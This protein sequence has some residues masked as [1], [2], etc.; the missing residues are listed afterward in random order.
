MC[1]SV[2]HVC[3]Y[4]YTHCMH[5]WYPEVPIGSP[6]T[7]VTFGCE[8]PYGCWKS[9]TGLLQEQ[10]LLIDKPLLQPHVGVFLTYMSVDHMC[11]QCQ[12]RIKEGI[13]YSRTRVTDNSGLPYGCQESNLGLLEVQSM[14]WI[15]DH[16]S[17]LPVC[18]LLL[19]FCGGGVVVGL[20]LFCFPSRQDPILQHRLVLLSGHIQNKL[21]QNPQA[22][23]CLFP[24]C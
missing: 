24:K 9:N 16:L 3:I 21:S 14:L 20:F 5:S 15:A 8:L 12:Q 19:L 17:A 10:V 4:T 7:G 11:V 23:F 22:S 18:C 6:E 1:M 13:R 2:L